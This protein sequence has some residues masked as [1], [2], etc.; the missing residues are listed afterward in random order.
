MRLFNVLLVYFLL[1]FLASDVCSA[2]E[3]RG[4]VP[5]KSTR[6]DVERLLGTSSDKNLVRY[7]LSK[8]VV[9]IEYAE[10][11]CDHTNPVGWPA[12]PPTWNVPKD[13][14]VSIGVYLKQPSPL[15]SFQIDLTKFKKT[16]GD[17]DL[18]Q[19][20]YYVNEQEGLSIKVLEYSGTKNGIAKGFIYQPASKDDHLRCPS[21]N[22]PKT[23]GN[24]LVNA[25]SPV[26]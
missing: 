22:Q 16:H 19:H 6:A 14:V 26:N 4:I 17:H 11:S 8:E 3:W 2:K 10:Y 24:R 20:F 1:M 5:L 15:S 13:T 23:Y 9:Y 21:L 7:E 12:P 18:P 25:Y